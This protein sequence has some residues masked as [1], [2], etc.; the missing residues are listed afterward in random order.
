M[1]VIVTPRVLTF[2]LTL[3]VVIFLVV[4]NVRAE[5]LPPGI[6]PPEVP[7]D[8]QPT[9]EKIALGKKLY[10]DKRLS[11][12]DTVSCASCHDPSMGFADGLVFSK[13]VGG[14]FGNRNAPTVLNAAFFEVQF[15]DGRAM[16]L[17][18]QAKGPLINPVEMAM[19]SHKALEKKLSQIKEYK[20]EFKKVFGTSRVNIDD[21]ARAI[22]AFERTLISVSSPFDKFIGGDTTA[23]T[24]EAKEGW[25]LFNGKA[26]CDSCHGYI[27]VY[28]LFTDNK[29]HNIGV[30]MNKQRIKDALRSV[31]AG[32]DTKEIEQF[33]RYNVTKNVKDLGSYKT[34]GLRNVELTA[35]YMHD[36]SEP[37]LE[38]VINFYDRGGNPNPNL[39][40]GMK[41][42]GLTEKEKASLVE[43]LKALTSDDLDEILN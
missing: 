42:L 35:P 31:Q 36:G 10:F 4:I 29:F 33:G 40:G 16:T 3:L 23:I 19:P 2:L 17:E 18:D 38:A 34:P 1:K 39:D 5:K 26:R 43:F 6:L 20:K 15:W 27:E 21:L 22:A 11:V 37:T 8:N 24:G 9:G 30:D 13:G 7:E 12:D 28:P 32:T 14:K 41:E 25:K